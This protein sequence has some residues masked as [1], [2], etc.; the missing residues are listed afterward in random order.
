MSPIPVNL[1]TGFLGVGKTTAILHLLEGHPAGERWAVLVNEFGE[2]GVDATLVGGDGVV[3]REV[4]GGCL[5]CVTAPVFTTV[6]NRMIRRDRPDRILIEPSGLG[7]PA[8]VLDTL[9]GAGYAG[10]LDIRATLCLLDARHLS[11]VRHREHPVFQDQVHLADVLVANKTDLYGDTDHE[12]FT[13]FVLALDPPKQTVATVSAARVD[14]AWLDI[15]RS[16]HRRAHFPEAHAFLVDQGHAAPP[17]D[18]APGFGD[19]QLITGDGNGYHR[20]GWY[21]AGPGG[22]DED[23]LD[24]LLAGI[25]AE[26]VKGVF[27]TERGWR[28]VNDGQWS[29][30]GPPDDARARLEIIDPNPIPVDLVDQRLRKLAKG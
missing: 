9:T 28:G 20:A 12:A 27:P 18:T 10:V 23:A 21:I 2:V 4:A 24:T 17:P 5:C 29:D 30:I 7:H 13:R 19:W 14:P 16:D 6:L 25:D 22:W 11:S 3:V 15:T 8:Q 26:R 1:V